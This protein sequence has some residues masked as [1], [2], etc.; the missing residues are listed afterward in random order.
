LRQVQM[1]HNKDRHMLLKYDA[2][3]ETCYK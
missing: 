2:I 3:F 1:E